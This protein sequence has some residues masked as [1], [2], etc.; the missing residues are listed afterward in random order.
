MATRTQAENNGTMTASHP[1]PMSRRLRRREISEMGG[2]ASGVADYLGLRPRLLRTGLIV[3]MLIFGLE[4]VA[5]YLAAWLMIPKTSEPSPQPIALASNPRAIVAGFVLLG[6]VFLGAL[7]GTR[8]IAGGDDPGLVIATG[9][10][11]VGLWLLIRRKEPKPSFG[12]GVPNASWSD[13]ASPDGGSPSRPSPSMPSPSMAVPPVWSPPKVEPGPLEPDFAPAPDWMTQ[14]SPAGPAVPTMA[15]G[16]DQPRVPG[17]AIPMVAPAPKPKPVGPRV[18][19]ITLAASAVAIGLAL[20]LNAIWDIDNSATIILG[21]VVALLGLGIVA[22]SIFERALLLL[23]MA[24]LSLGLLFVAPLIDGAA[25][26]GFG[27]RSLEVSETD[28]LQSSYALGAGE[29]ILDLSGLDLSA[30]A[31]GADDLDPDTVGRTET[32]DVQV[33]AGS[34]RIIV[35]DGVAVRVIA[36]NRAGT[37]TVDNTVDEGVINRLDHRFAS[38]LDPSMGSLTIRVDVTFGE[39]VVHRG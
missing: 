4:A 11:L 22:S 5:V 12:P 29:L 7:S 34:A 6:F 38:S 9:V 16:Q 28:V 26:G 27:V 17:W 39:I 37:I 35:P 21:A 15:S 1:A 24:M 13:P 31:P 25:R 14:Q 3:L 33:G 32:V 8:L 19:S 30:P 18:T 2:V 10:M 36:S 20:T 23:P